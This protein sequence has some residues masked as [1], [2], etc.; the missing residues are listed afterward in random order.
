[1]PATAGSYVNSAIAHIDFVQ[2]DTTATPSDNSP[3]TAT[4]TVIQRVAG[5]TITPDAGTRPSVVAGQ[6]TPMFNFRVTNTGNFTDQI[7]FLANGASARVTGPATITDIVIDTDNSQTVSAADTDIKNNAADVLSASLPP[8]GFINVIVRVL[9]DLTAAQGDAITVTLGDAATGGPTF[10]DQAANSSANEVRTVSTTSSNGLREARGDM[11]ALVDNDAQILLDMTAPSGPVPLGSDITYTLRV[12]NPGLRD[13]GGQTLTNAPPGS[14]SGIFIIKPIPVGTVLKSGQVFP[15]GTLYTTSAL[16]VDPLTAVWTTTPP[17]DLTT[18]KRIAF[19]AGPTLAPGALSAV[20]SVIVTITTNDATNPIQAIA[21]SF[22]R[23][24]IGIGLTDQ[25]GDISRNVGDGNA[26]FNES[27]LRG[28]ID[29]DGIILLTTLQSVG[30]VLI[31]PL[32]QPGAV[33][34][35]NNNDDYTNSSVTTGITGV[36]PGGTT[37]APGTVVFT[38][39]VQNTGN[40]GDTCGS[41]TIAVGF[42]ASANILVRV[43]APAGQ[44]VLTP[45]ATVIRATSTNTPASANDTIDRLYTGFI[46]LVKTATVSNTTGGGGATAPVPG[47]VITYAI[48]YTNVSSTGGTNNVVLTAYDL[49]ITEDGNLAPNNWGSATV[50]LIG[51][52]DTRGGAITGDTIGST[53]LTDTIPVL[54]PGQSGIFTFKRTIR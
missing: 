19:N 11:T 36:A 34:P 42:G 7:R 10:D 35:A 46:R 13:L 28:T 20:I 39:T 32:G 41:T 15:A 27:P 14:N 38:N 37:S 23:N 21:D 49:I 8:N 22:G 4:V 18:L 40:A 2:I 45:Y 25:S 16:S 54:T 43:T 53:L 1:M 9:V 44:T 6:A 31:G 26:N 50:H 47:A 48:S 33:G 5:I 29:G 12:S 17:A 3:A 51:A 52:T 30:G 24:T